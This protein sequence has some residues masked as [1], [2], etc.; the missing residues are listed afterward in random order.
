MVG[1]LR[2]LIVAALLGLVAKLIAKAKRSAE[3]TASPDWPTWSERH[4]SPDSAKTEQTDP[5]PAT[6]GDRT[7]I[8]ARPSAQ[9]PEGASDASTWV[10]AVEGE[11]PV[12][13]AEIGRAHV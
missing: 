8:D 12:G 7:D 4:G 1:L 5:E 13:Y 9:S 3:P 10:E 6:T 11:C 2:F